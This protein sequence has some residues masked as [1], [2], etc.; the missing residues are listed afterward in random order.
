[1]ATGALAWGFGLIAPSLFVM[2]GLARMV[3]TAE[4]VALRRRPPRPVAGIVRDLP[5][6]HVAAA[7]VRLPDGRVVPELVVGP[8]GVAV[9]EELPRPE[10]LAARTR[11]GGRREPPTGAGSRSRTRSIV[12]AG[13]PSGSV[14]GSLTTTATTSSRSTPRS[15]I[16][17]RALSRTPTCAVVAPDELLAWIA[18]LPVQRSLN[19]DRRADIV[20]TIKGALV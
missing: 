18:S 7:R 14:A 13:T 19:A 11:A 3:E 2:I 10:H 8:F 20:E 15:S 4:L 9:V 17:R 5:P 1:M 16:A 6:D 12:P